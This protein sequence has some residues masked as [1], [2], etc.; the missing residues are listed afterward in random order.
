MFK[1]QQSTLT[2]LAGHPRQLLVEDLPGF[3]KDS[4]SLKRTDLAQ[5]EQERPTALSSHSPIVQ[6]SYVTL[7]IS[8]LAPTYENRFNIQLPLFSPWAV[9][10]LNLRIIVLDAAGCASS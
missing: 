9:D 1:N 3:F 5:R 7:V 2:D 6:A 8:D 4:I 10:H